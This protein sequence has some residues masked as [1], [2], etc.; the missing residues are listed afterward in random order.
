MKWARLGSAIRGRR[1][2]ISKRNVELFHNGNAAINRG[3][4][5]YLV[6]HS[7]E[8][9]VVIAA[10]GAV[11]GAFVGHEGLR[12]FF[13]DN[14]ANFEVFQVRYQDVRD[15]GDDRVLA[16]GTIHIRSR[17]AGVETDIPRR[18]LQRIGKGS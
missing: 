12:K 13:A 15:L 16:I 18:A 2:L 10:R 1:G 17:G 3:D 9:V 8:D 4:V 7:T 6:R 11:E 14:A 5:E